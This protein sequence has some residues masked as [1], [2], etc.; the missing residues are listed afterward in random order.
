MF[1]A[2]YNNINKDRRSGFVFEDEMIYRLEEIVKIRYATHDEDRFK[3]TDCFIDDVPV[4]LTLSLD[5][6]D[7]TQVIG[8]VDCWG[9]FKITVGIRYGNAHGLFKQPVCVLCF[10]LI[11][12]NAKRAAHYIAQFVDRPTI[13]ECLDM[14]KAALKTID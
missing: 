3:G 10:N 7:L 5:R 4:D 13:D 8:N 2:V 6:K 9:V 12:M 14:Y 1:N 11:G